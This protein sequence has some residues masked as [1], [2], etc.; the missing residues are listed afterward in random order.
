MR[1]RSTA[2][3]GLG[4]HLGRL[5][6]ILLTALVL[7][8]LL[9]TGVSA[10]DHWSDISDQDWLDTYQV[11][12]QEVRAVAEGFGDGTFRPTALV[13][14]AQ[15]AKMAVDG[16]GVPVT[17]PDAPTFSDTPE[18]DHFYPWIEGAAATHLIGG[19]A[20]GSFRGPQSISRQQANSMVGLYLSQRELEATGSLQGEKG[21]YASLSE[22]YLSEGA[23]LLA[24]FG[25]ALE[26]A[27]AHAQPTAYLVARGVIKGSGF[28]A[29]AGDTR[30][31][32]AQ[33]SLTR[34]QAA[35]M[36]IRAKGVTFTAPATLHFSVTGIPDPLTAGEASDV[37]V[38]VLDQSD[39]VATGYT[40]AVHFASTDGQAD[41]PADY[42]FETADAG[43]RTFAGGV[44]LHTTG[45]Q[46]VS[47]TDTADRT[48]TGS[49]TMTVVAG[50]GD[51]PG[52]G[53]APGEVTPS[54][55]R[56]AVTTGPGPVV[57]GVP[58]DLTVAVVDSS[59][60]VLTTYRG[61]VFFS[62]SDPRATLPSPY[63]FTRADQGLRV[64]PG[65]VVLR[66]A[67]P[68]IIAVR[69]ASGTILDT[70]RVN[71]L[72]GAATALKIETAPDGSGA[73]IGARTIAA[74]GTLTAYAV[75]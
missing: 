34:A 44:V 59:S 43:S 25:D 64:F 57:A 26:V 19:Y 46:T 61:R 12:A 10:A 48:V 23:E 50:G 56:F 55:A 54:V 62:S 63:M 74:G 6:L 47:A 40:G 27:Q 31:L 53:G 41:L 22:W 20:D 38:T 18:S 29:A 32:D 8:L 5:V 72:P 35:A 66:T 30:Y 39:N 65:S 11:S 2:I 1:I 68:Q 71:V 75:G 28:A 49:R 36:I 13:S 42:T 21:G 3:A 52:G 9:T 73:E 17:R 37:T 24:G 58:V 67:G 4:S 70:L 7:M 60:T 33:G 16:L 14:R 51:A 45:V 15:F 69:D